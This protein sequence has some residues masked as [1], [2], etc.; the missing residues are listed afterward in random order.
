MKPKLLLRIFTIAVCAA[1][2]IVV[3]RPTTHFPSHPH[4]APEFE[5]RDLNGNQV[6]LS[7]FRGKA[8]VFNFW[9]TWC[10][11]CR[12]EIP[13]FIEFQK[14]YGPR[15]LQIIG[16]SMDDGASDAIGSFVRRIGIDYVVLLGDSH[17]SSLYGGVEVLP[18]TYYI[19]P[20]G[21]VI[22]SVNGMISKTEVEQDIKEVLGSSVQN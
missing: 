18:T 2:L 17:V 14:E 16:V 1:L 10:A 5:L 21:G 8:I 4:Q 12:R 6:H 3:N 19:S 22:A 11:P 20:H 9:A 15:R 7:D 13:W